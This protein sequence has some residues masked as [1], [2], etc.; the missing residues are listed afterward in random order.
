MQSVILNSILHAD[1]KNKLML[2][3]QRDSIMSDIKSGRI[4]LDEIAEI[5]LKYLDLTNL[6]GVPSQNIMTPSTAFK[7]FRYDFGYKMW[8]RQN[9]IHWL[10]E[11]V[12]LGKDLQDWK[13]KLSN[14]ERNLMTHMFP[15]FVQNDVL[16]NNVYIDQYAKIFRPNELQLAFS[17]IANAESIHQVAYSH[18]LTELGLPESHYSAFLEYKEMADKYNFTAGFR[19][20]TL[21]GIALALLVFGALTEGLQ[22]FASFAV[23]FNF[24]RHNK[25]NGMGQIVSWSVRDE[26]LHV[27]FVA[28]IFKHFMAEYG[29]LLDKKVLIERT[30][31]AARGIVEGEHKFTDLA[32]ELGGVEGLEAQDVKDYVCHTADFRLQQFGLPPIYNTPI[33][34]IGDWIDSLMGG[35]E[36]A[37]F[38]EQ[39]GTEYSRGATKGTWAEA[40]AG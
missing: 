17:A 40:F 27:S 9:Q 14:A 11:S 28:Q 6:P 1:L 22:L 4:P 18:L 8:E 26:S 2:E 30:N 35:I 36:H 21:M 13:T 10:H 34:P 20:D 15:L 19:M 24:T 33:G 32:F 31:E 25:L 38:F 39:R 29:H 5:P 7:P 23:M 16:V 3:E 37:N 12:P